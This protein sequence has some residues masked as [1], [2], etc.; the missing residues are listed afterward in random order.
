M[1]PKARSGLTIVFVEVAEGCAV[2]PVDI[3]RVDGKR[4]SSLMRKDLTMFT[5]E[6]IVAISVIS[7]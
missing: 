4:S 5:K 7:S 1:L 3:F 2:R 6:F